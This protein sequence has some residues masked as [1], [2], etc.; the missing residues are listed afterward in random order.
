MSEENNSNKTSKKDG[1]KNWNGKGEQIGIEELRGQ[2]YIYGSKG[3]QE[4][5][6]KTTKAVAEYAGSTCGKDMW[7]L[8]HNQ[9]EATFPEPPEPKEDASRA[10]M[11]KYK[12]LFRMSIEDKKQYDKDK[13]RMFRII[14]G[15]CKLSM[16]NKIES[17]AEYPKLEEDDDVVGL[18]AMMKQVAFSA[19]KVQ[20]E[21][22]T[23]QAMMRK[24]I[25]MKQDKESI[26]G[27]HKRFM[28]QLEV[29]EQAWGKLIP[30]EMKGKPTAEQEAARDKFLACVFLA[31]VDRSRSKGAINDLSN[32]FL[33][34][35]DCYPESIPAMLNYLNNR[36]DA[37]ESTVIE[38][39]NDGV[40]A[41]SFAQ[42]QKDISQVKCYRCKKKGHYA[43]T[44]TTE[45]R[46]NWNEDGTTTQTWSGFQRG[47]FC[48]DDDDNDR[49]VTWSG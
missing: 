31:G 45:L 6:T 49:E 13:S 34:G 2:F 29:T 32:D 8:V 35:S 39:M 20:Y 33:G 9:K 18:L 22:W 11:E 7:E 1:K 48:H 38:D 44:C 4:R 43:S 3:Q 42:G 12:M 30:H 17:M 28:A 19:E 21:F 23:K 15:Q 16:K 14:M 36:R 5:F 47:A 46:G 37:K 41:T 27:F 10:A 26:T 40:M 24:L 25:T